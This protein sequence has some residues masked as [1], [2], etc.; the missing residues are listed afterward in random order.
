MIIPP[1][2]RRVLLGCLIA[3]SVVATGLVVIF[4]PRTS[5][6]TRFKIKP[7]ATQTVR[8][9]LAQQPESTSPPTH[10]TPVAMRPELSFELPVLNYH[11]I[12]VV[13]NQ[14]TDPLGFNLS[15][16]PKDFTAQMAYLST[17]HY[18]T[19]TPD[20]L[21]NALRNQSPL[22]PK[23]VLLTFDDGYEDFYTDAFPVLQKYHFRATIFIIT[24]LVGEKPSNYLSWS[25][26]REL[27]KSGLITI[28]SHTI[29]HV[30]VAT[31]RNAYNEIYGSKATLERE[32]GHPIT[33][34]AYPSGEHDAASVAMVAA[35][36]YRVAFTTASSTTMRLS[37]RDALPRIRIS[38]GL[39]ISEFPIKLAP[40]PYNLMRHEQHTIVQPSKLA[41]ALTATPISTTVKT[42]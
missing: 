26:V 24:G 5:S 10:P 32:L 6:A 28:G 13:A 25:Q 18:L 40:L 39:P 1:P 33:A 16:T 9:T 8:T 3:L 41:P 31:S 30:D 20:D 27:D 23:S 7:E 37:E 19:I 14:H 11:Y 15:V 2:A 12:R 34:F 17:H 21:Y 35:A 4:D 36:G 22:P 29:H 42:Y 38:G